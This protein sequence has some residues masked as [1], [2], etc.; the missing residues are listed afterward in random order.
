MG[1]GTMK[2]KKSRKV[3]E[4]KLERYLRLNQHHSLS[5]NWWYEDPMKNRDIRLV[6]DKYSPGKLRVVFP[7]GGA[8]LD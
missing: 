2:R 5:S 1:V 8:V 4:L 7:E 6:E 3:S